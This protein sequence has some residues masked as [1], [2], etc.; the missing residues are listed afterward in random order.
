MKKSSIRSSFNE[1]CE[2]KDIN[3]LRGLAYTI[4]KAEH[5]GISIPHFD[6]VFG[7]SIKL[8]SKLKL[9]SSIEFRLTDQYLNLRDKVEID[10]YS[11]SDMGVTPE[12]A[13]EGHVYE[14]VVA[15]LQKILDEITSRTVQGV[16][17][18]TSPNARWSTEKYANL[19]GYLKP[20]CEY[21]VSPK[22]AAA[23]RCVHHNVEIKEQDQIFYPFYH[24]QSL[25]FTD[26]FATEDFVLELPKNIVVSLSPEI[27]LR[28]RPRKDMIDAWVVIGTI[29]LEVSFEPVGLINKIVGIDSAEVFKN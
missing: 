10:Y 4:F 29:P 11:E 17:D 5:D 26:M 15:L 16:I 2:F 19:S 24:N 18:I 14:T 28:P 13:M 21:I 3:N 27:T 20:N 9:A 22:V 23:L 6:E 8:L 7:E 12:M 25:V 1:I